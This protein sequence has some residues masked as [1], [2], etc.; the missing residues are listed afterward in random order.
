MKK[1]ERL[2]KIIEILKERG[3]AK[4]TELAKICGV[5]RQII[6][7]DINILRIRNFEIIST[8]EGYLLMNPPKSY[9]E[10]LFVV[11]HTKE[12][13]EKELQI[14]VE[15]GGEVV[16]VIVE[17]PIYG[18]IEKELNIKT[19]EDV[20]IFVAAL[21]TAK[22]KPLLTLSDGIHLHYVRSKSLENL[23]L[24]EKKLKEAGFLI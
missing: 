20:K 16:N 19:L 8:E 5:T 3:V 22:T 9:Y 10:R 17:H 7:Q 6:S 11:K 15:N 2:K 13:I 14:I 18:K 4:G 12:D 1:E 21:E 23:D 24:I